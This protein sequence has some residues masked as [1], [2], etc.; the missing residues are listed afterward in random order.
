MGDPRSGFGPPECLAVR[1]PTMEEPDATR[2]TSER[3]DDRAPT[4][5]VFAVA[6]VVTRMNSRFDFWALC[7]EPSTAG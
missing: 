1:V 3:L 6:D 4:G 7:D 5:R 2:P